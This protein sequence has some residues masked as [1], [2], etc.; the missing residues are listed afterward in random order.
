MDNE[1]LTLKKAAKKLGISKCTLY[2]WVNK[3]WI[4]YV[5]LPNSSI[6]IPQDAIDSILTGSR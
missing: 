1:L 2:R 6:R 5:R 3:D 4:R